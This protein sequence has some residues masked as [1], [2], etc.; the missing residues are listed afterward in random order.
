MVKFSQDSHYY[1]IVRA[2][3]SQIIRSAVQ[4]QNGKETPTTTE[5]LPAIVPD[6]VNES[7]DGANS[8]GLTGPRTE[9]IR[10]HEPRSITGE[11]TRKDP[12]AEVEVP[13]TEIGS[14]LG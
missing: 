1:S 12:E 13:L 6:E 4:T 14:G 11:V 7:F 8:Q 2:K 3:L 5:D 10:K 9:R